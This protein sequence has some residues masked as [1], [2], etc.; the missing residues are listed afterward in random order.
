MVTA[1]ILSPTC[2]QH[3]TIRVLPAWGVKIKNR[4][5]FAPGAG[6]R[7]V[8]GSVVRDRVNH[9]LSPAVAPAQVMTSLVMS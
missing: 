8:F 7:P 9:P 5:F 4:P 1:S 3:W 2:V 6:Y